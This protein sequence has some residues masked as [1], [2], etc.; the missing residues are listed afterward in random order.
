LFRIRQAKSFPQVLL[1]TCF[2]GV[3]NAILSVKE[4]QPSTHEFTRAGRLCA[5]GY[6]KIGCLTTRSA[7]TLTGDAIPGREG[8]FVD[9]TID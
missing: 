6:L 5:S 8:T 4:R 9:D 3:S 7:T 1:A 2:E